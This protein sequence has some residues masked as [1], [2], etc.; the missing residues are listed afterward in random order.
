MPAGTLR[1]RRLAPPLGF[2]SA[3]WRM[4]LTEKRS[5]FHAR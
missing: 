4:L 1:P 2:G 5:D 3:R